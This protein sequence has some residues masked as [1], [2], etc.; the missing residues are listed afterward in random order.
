MPITLIQQFQTQV[1]TIFAEVCKDMFLFK[2]VHSSIVY[3]GT[4]LD[5][6]QISINRD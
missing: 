1:F 4:A 2:N 3:I 5:V 6:T